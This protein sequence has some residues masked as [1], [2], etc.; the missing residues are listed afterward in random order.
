MPMERTQATFYLLEIAIFALSVTLCEI[1]TVEMC[2]TLAL[3]FK[4][5]QGQCKYANRTA[6]CDFLCV[7]N[8]NACPI[9]HRFR[10]NQV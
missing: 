8:S 3:T 9:C 10:G 7:G 1:L 2:R 6:T 5:G 4:M